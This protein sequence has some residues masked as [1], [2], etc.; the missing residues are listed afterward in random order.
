MLISR[1]T[2]CCCIYKTDVYKKIKY[3]FE[4][5]GKLHDIIFMMEVG[6]YGDIAFLHGE[7][8]RWR[9]HIGSDSNNLLTGPYPKEILEVLIAIKTNFLKQKQRDG[10][11]QYI[12]RILFFA[13]LFNF[14][15]FLYEWSDLKRFVNWETFKAMMHDRGIFTS[16]QYKVFDLIIDRM[17]NPFIRIEAKRQNK[18][19]YY[20]YSYRV[21]K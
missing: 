15:Y 16:S 13:L 12:K 11:K 21:G 9:Q 14:S 4:Q 18:K 5:Y 7:C 6:Q 3:K 20:N 2:F 17:L 19:H 10:L 8:V 1:P